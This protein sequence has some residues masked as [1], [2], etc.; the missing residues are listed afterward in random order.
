MNDYEINA[1]IRLLQNFDSFDYFISNKYDH[2]ILYNTE[3]IQSLDACHF[4]TPYC[5]KCPL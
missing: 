4:S 3:L 1:T 5:L 2:W